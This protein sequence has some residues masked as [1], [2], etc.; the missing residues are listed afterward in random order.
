MVFGHDG[1][2]SGQGSFLRWIPATRT[3]IALLANT[4]P[5]AMFLW[6]GLSEWFFER[7]G[8]TVPGPLEAAPGASADDRL[9]G[10]YR[11][12]DATFAVIPHDDLLELQVD[13][14]AGSLRTTVTLEPLQAGVYR[15]SAMIADPTR[16]VTFE[17][18]DGFGTL[19]H[20]GPFAARR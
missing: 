10:E 5:A 1:G 12:R 2:A 20:C 4:A 16:I 13:A 11:C 3:G 19:L 14:L 8:V 6:A 7:A 17:E 9:C 15:A 18:L